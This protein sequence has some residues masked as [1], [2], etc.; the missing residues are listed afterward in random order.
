VSGWSGRGGWRGGERGRGC[1][2]RRFGG[3][4][5]GDGLMGGW[6]DGWEWGVRACCFSGGG[7]GRMGGCGG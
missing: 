7:G 5:W 6:M 1:G 3:G 2:G 4:D